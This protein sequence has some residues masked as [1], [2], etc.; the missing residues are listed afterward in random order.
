MLLLVAGPTIHTER[1]G[2]SIAF[3]V[4]LLTLLLPPV[5][6][7]QK[8]QPKSLQ[9]KSLTV[10]GVVTDP[11]GEPLVGVT[12][13][14]SNGAKEAVALAGTATN[15]KGEYSIVVPRTTKS[16]VFEFIGLES[17]TIAIGNRTVLNV[18]MKES[19]VAVDAVVV[20]GIFTRK[21]ESFTGAVQTI[22]AKTLEQVSNQNA[23]Q[24][25]KN[26]DPSLV[27]LDNLEQ[28]SNP[29]A[30]SSMQLRGASSFSTGDSS[31]KS[32]FVDDPNMPLFVLDGFETTAEKV[33]DMDMNRIESITILKDASAKAIYGSKAGNGVIVIETKSLRSDQTLVG[34]NGNLTIEIPDLSSYNLCNA[35]EKLEIERREGYYETLGTFSPDII[36]SLKLYQTRLKRALE[37]ESTYWLSKPV[38]LSIGNKHSL[39]VEIGNRDLKSITSFS[40][41]DNQG[42]MKGSDRRTLSGS[43]NLSY[44]RNKWQFRNIMSVSSMNSNDSPYG[45]FEK[46]TELNP[47]ESPYTDDGQLR[48]YLSAVNGVVVGNPLYDAQL[49]TILTDEYLDFTDN[50]YA[51]YN[52]FDFL[53][54]VAR[55]G[56]ST[57]RTS[58]EEFYPA[59]HS[60]FYMTTASSSDEQKLQAGSYDATNG[61]QSILSGDFSA[62]LNKSFKG[63]H[64]LFATF[65]YSISQQ[66]YSEVTHYTTGFPNSRMN[67][68]TYARQYALNATPTGRKGLNRNIGI[69]GTAG[70]SYCDRY[71][72]DATLRSNASSAFG[73][74]NR[75]ALFWSTGVAWN[76]HKEEFFKYSDWLEQ[77]KLRA[78][79]GSSGNQNYSSTNSL[80]VYN[81]YNDSFYNGFTGVSLDNMENPYLGWEQKTDYNVGLDFR[82]KRSTIVIDAYIS[83]TENLIFNRSLLPS[84]GF[85]S[86]SDNLGKVRNKGLEFSFSYRVFSGSNGFF[87]INTKIAYNDNR[88]LEISDALRSYNKEQQTQAT[89]SNS[90]KPVIQYYDG[91]ALNAVWAVRS[92]GIDPV[93]GKEIFLDLDGNMTN[94]WNA[95]NL[96]YCGTSDPKFN[97]NFGFNTEFFNIGLNAICTFYGGGKK[98]NSTLVDKVENVYIGSNVDRRIYASRWYYAGQQ[99]QYRDGYSSNTQAT[100]RFVQDDNVLSVSS[101]SLYYDVPRK[102]IERLGLERLKLSFYAN[103]L[104]TFSSIEIERGTSYPYARSFSF[105]V[106]ATF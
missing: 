103:D 59:N 77:L 69:L 56:V 53:K 19:A 88:I 35:L 102:S 3:C 90:T 101:I 87:N 95:S 27:V 49:N 98:Y 65:Q 52:M 12:V 16:L 68:I 36:E 43:M 51:E 4:L 22:S 74:N 9:T 24:A 73:T 14:P 47:Y 8:Q 23:F 79:V 82:T 34:Y 39:S 21:A 86:F 25:L 48:R 40:Y 66:E 60:K 78:S 76:L 104:F 75:W 94:Q 11:A 31:L 80:A 18:T 46:Y 13:T 105:S 58:I 1:A 71:M 54:L 5:A 106:S 6:V 26:L 57:K 100:T 81:Y 42:V 97:G 99:A 17:Q 38:R 28:G 45:S 61:A 32:N 84:V 55:I 50:L 91:C 93:S 70:Y 83:D 10:K 89:E 72:V 15:R 96:V 64:D 41:N 29:N 67:D 63:G 33:M 85:G 92:L 7:A 20:T 30:V 44:R 62:Q 2:K 37:G